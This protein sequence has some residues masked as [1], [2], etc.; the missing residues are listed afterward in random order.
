MEYITLGYNW[1]MSN[2]TAALGISQL[3]KLDK[4]ITMRREKAAYLSKY[5]SNVS[6][7][8]PPDPPNGYFH[9]YQMYTIKVKDGKDARDNLKNYLAEK[10]VM[11]KVYFS[12]VHLKE[13]YRNRCGFQGGEL[14]TTE[15]LSKKVLTLPMYASLT[16]DEMNFIVDHVKRFMKNID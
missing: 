9:V 2:I 7:I 4:F 13:F 11:T 6:G 8:E 10:G 16:T 1:R 12:P 3:K 15:E 14:P 5:L